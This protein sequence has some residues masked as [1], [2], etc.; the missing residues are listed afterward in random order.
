M[1]TYSKRFVLHEMQ[2]IGTLETSDDSILV[3]A[4]FITGASHVIDNQA[5]AAMSK[6]LYPRPVSIKIRAISS[7]VDK[8][9]V[10]NLIRKKGHHS[11]QPEYL[12][13]AV[14]QNLHKEGKI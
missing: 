2:T 13:I 11:G 5:T 3:Q 14:L 10:D 9:T 7:D 12:D 8:E 6:N 1:D 4:S